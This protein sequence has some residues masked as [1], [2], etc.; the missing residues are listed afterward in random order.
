MPIPVPNV[1]PY[2]YHTLENGESLSYLSYIYNTTIEEL[3]RMNDLAGPEAPLQAG[4]QL[5]VPIRIN[6]VAPQ[7]QLLPDSE[8]VYGPA[9]AT[10]DIAEFVDAQGGYFANYREYV[11]GQPLSGAQVIE[12][13]AQR[14]SVGPR[15]LL[16]Q[17]EYYGNWVTNPNPSEWQINSPLGPRNPYSN[18]Y[19]ALTFTANE[20]NAGY[21]G[22]K[23]DGFWIFRLADRSRAMTPP[24]LNA[25]TVGVLN[26]LAAHANS[27][28]WVQAI[29]PEGFI[30]T[31]RT[32]FGDPD[33][34]A[35]EPLIP[36]T[37]TQPPLTLPWKKGQGFYYTGGPHPAYIDGSGWAA[38]DFGPPDVLGNCFYSFEPNTAAADG[39][40]AIVKQGEVHLD[41]DGDG[42][43]QTGWGLLY[44][45]MALD[46]DTPLQEGQPVKEGDVIG[47]ASCEGGVSN[48]SHLH[49]ARR[50]NG[51]W[52]D[53]G[54]PVPLNLS[55]WVVQ[56]NP[57]PYAGTMS[58]DN[59]VRESCECWE[60]DLNL[61]VRD[62]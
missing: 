47:Y 41:L 34:H 22:Y 44:L 24:G 6:T 53:A 20:V 4:D 14:F 57:L 11:D 48:S 52:M 1:P 39:V 55:G 13:I 2:I 61:I 8:V 30:Q 42:H 51:E 43:I 59:I 5:R 23:R 17:V 10:F 29:G 32:L 25:G 49:F 54:G 18:L 16:A 50:Y 60:P 27:D 45:H 19:F 26:I 62:K 37:L 28:E 46:L 21:Y 7:V 56:P 58:K 15:L 3:V 9:Y 40:A 36:E 35:V 38:I 31:Y 12:R 33:T